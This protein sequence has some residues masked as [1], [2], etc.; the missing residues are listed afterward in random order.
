MATLMVMSISR[1]IPPQRHRGTEKEPKKASWPFPCVSASRCLCG[2]VFQY[3]P[4]GLRHVLGRK[5]EMLEQLAGRR[6]LAEA[7]DTDHRALQ[8]DILAPVVRDPRFHS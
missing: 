5:A 8:P 7:V 2:S 3:S 4:H 1:K 6:G